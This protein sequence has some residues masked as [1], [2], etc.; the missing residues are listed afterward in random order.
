M[1]A[2][3]ATLEG[4]LESTNYPVFSV[5]RNYCY[6]SF[7]RSHAATMKA[8]YGADIE[9]GKSIL[10]YPTTP[11]DRSLAKANLD[12]TLRGERLVLEEYVGDEA[13]LRSCFEISHNPIKRSDGEV[14]GVAVFARDITEKKRAEEA[15]RESEERFRQAMEATNDGLW[16]WNV[17]SGDVYYSPAYSRILVMKPPSL[18]TARKAGQT[19]C[20]QMTEKRRSK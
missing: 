19:S 12:R 2:A 16:D 18:P 15:L 7:N 5:D 11:Q 6:T 3:H 20:T 14:G 17:K 13:L 4:I 9:L 1:E 8:I 10:A